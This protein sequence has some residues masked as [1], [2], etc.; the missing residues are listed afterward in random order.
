MLTDASQ[1]PH[2][3]TDYRVFELK[4]G[5]YVLCFQFITWKAATAYCDKHYVGH[6]PNPY[7]IVWPET[8]I[9]MD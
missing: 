3:A 1:L 2:H 7:V 5:R 4:N 6:G 8:P 9:D